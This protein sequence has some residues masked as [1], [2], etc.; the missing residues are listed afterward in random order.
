MET[1]RMPF[2]GELVIARI[3]KVAQFSAHCRLIEYGD[4]DAFIP[5]R[6]VSSGW[7]KN[8]HEYVHTGQIVVCKIT[9]ID[10]DKGTIDASIK[11]V[12]PK[13]ARDKLNTYNL[14]KRLFAL[15]QQAMKDAKVSPKE[16][17]EAYNDYVLGSFGTFTKFIKEAADKTEASEQAKLPKKLKESLAKLIE[18]SKK[19][20]EHKVSYMLTLSVY[21][22]QNGISQIRQLLSDIEASHVG[23]DYIGAPRYRLSSEGPDYITAEQHVQAAAKLLK[24]RLKEGRFS[25][26]KEK[27]RKKQIDI[28]NRL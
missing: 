28:I 1:G 25:L 7:I 20:G 24:E 8:I 5:I 18:S 26:E 19:E 4:H 15:F 10:K 3:E 9:F 13:D 2:V 21:N 12:N 16:Q 14:E 22:T 27:L 6:E 17:R 23:V 11:K